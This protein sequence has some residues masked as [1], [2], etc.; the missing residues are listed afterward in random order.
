MAIK[1]LTIRYWGTTDADRQAAFTA[2]A[3]TLAASGWLTVSQH[4]EPPEG[5]PGLDLVVTYELVDPYT[6]EPTGR[7]VADPQEPRQFPK[8][9]WEK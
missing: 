5:N 6:G 2:D 3:L 9:P 1:H 8:P 7:P 4:T